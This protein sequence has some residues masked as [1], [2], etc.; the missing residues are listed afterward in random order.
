[1]AAVEDRE[2]YGEAHAAPPVRPSRLTRRAVTRRRS[3]LRHDAARDTTLT[4]RTFRRR[5]VPP[6]PQ[7]QPQPQPQPRRTSLRPA[8]GCGTTQTATCRPRGARPP[9]P[10][11]PQQTSRRP[12]AAPLPRLRLT[13]PPRGGL[14]VRPAA[15]AAAAA[16]AA[17]R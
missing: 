13:C 3:R 12:D 7:P 11:P 9:P 8:A 2:P 1:V 16:A 10:Q 15:A 4:T 6:R 14:A 17:V 5:G